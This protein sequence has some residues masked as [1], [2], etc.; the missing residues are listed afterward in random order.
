MLFD[1]HVSLTGNV[2]RDA[3]LRFTPGGMAVANF[4]L[5]QNDKKKD[6][7]EEV[8]HFFDVSCFR[9]LAENVAESISAGDRVTV[10]G[11]LRYRSWE[12]EDGSK[13]SKVEI[14]ADEVSA[15]MRWATVSIVKNAKGGGQS[16]SAEELAAAAGVEDF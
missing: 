5:A 15:S 3:E 4:G 14:V 11:T 8:A 2:T 16:A 12:A 9:G 10:T 7:D 6:S 13:R 1:N